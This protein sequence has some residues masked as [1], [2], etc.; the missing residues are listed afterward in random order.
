M[1]ADIV[2]ELATEANFDEDRYLAENPDVRKAGVNARYHFI[3]AGK[4]ERRMQFKEVSD[5][6]NGL[7]QNPTLRNWAAGS[8]NGLPNETPSHQVA[9]DLWKDDWWTAMP[10]ETGLLAGHADHFNDGR[11]IWADT[12]LGGI[13]GKNIIELGPFEAYNSYQ[14][15]RMGASKVVS[16]EN[17]PRNFMKC[18]IVKNIF[19]LNTTFL[20]GDFNLYEP[21][22]DTDWD[23]VWASGV[24]YHLTDPVGFLDRISKWG[25][26]IFLWTQYYDSNTL[27]EGH[28]EAGHFDLRKDTELY[29]KGRKIVLHH[30]DYPDPSSNSKYAGGSSEYSYWM[31]LEDIFYVLQMNGFSSIQMGINNPEHSHGPACFFIATRD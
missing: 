28:S 5:I 23:I 2:I 11:V 29:Y 3:K 25:K 10:A 8:S 4:F 19:N 24:L 16:L 20:L 30:R 9:L 6:I 13:K 15:D 18:L 14:F 22:R 26:R 31:E 12:A 17:S 1:I 7:N 27:S 21:D